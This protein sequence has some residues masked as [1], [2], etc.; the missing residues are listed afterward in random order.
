[1]EFYTLIE[2]P[3]ESD[4]KGIAFGVMVPCL[5]GCF[6]AGDTMEAAI[7]NAQ[8]AITMYIE[9]LLER[10]EPVPR[11]H[12]LDVVNAKK[13]AG[14]WIAVRIDV[15]EAYISTKAARVNVTIPEGVLAMIDDAAGK[16][17]KN[18]SAFLT[19]AALEKIKKRA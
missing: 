16:E 13:K 7:E 3:K 8:E 14:D 9:D 2:V 6:S 5:P 12:P 10:G 4:R 1:M 17:H 18:R 11:S 15:K 19:E